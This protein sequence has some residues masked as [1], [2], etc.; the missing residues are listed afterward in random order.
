MLLS[1][2]ALLVTLSALLG[3]GTATYVGVHGI[4]PN[5][6]Q[7]HVDAGGPISGSSTSTATSTSTSGA[8]P[9]GAASFAVGSDGNLTITL[10]LS[11]LLPGSAH[12]IDLET[13]G[14]P[15]IFRLDQS[16]IP[17]Q[18]I[19]ADGSGAVDQTIDTERPAVT[20]PAEPLAFAVRTGLARNIGDGGQNPVAST[21][22]LCAPLPAQLGRGGQSSTTSTTTSTQ[23]A[24]ITTAT[25]QT[26]ST[27]TTQATSSTA[28]TETAPT[29]STTPTETAPGPLAGHHF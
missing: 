14:C 15:S 3:G 10:Q 9:T 16:L 29:S 27:T 1:L 5:A 12:S 22:V 24:T 2:R 13:G 18:V 20:L 17:S 7:N 26:T 6:R 8:S 23:P 21:A 19:V 25:T 11:G 4:E 28:T